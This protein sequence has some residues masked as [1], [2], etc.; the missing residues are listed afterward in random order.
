LLSIL[1][2]GLNTDVKAPKGK[3]LLTW[4]PAGTVT[5]VLGGDEWAGGTN[6]ITFNWPCYQPDATVIVDGKPVVEKGELKVGK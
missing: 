2:F 5:L 6:A 1:D 4:V 3:Q